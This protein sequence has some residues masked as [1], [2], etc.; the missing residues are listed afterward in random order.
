VAAF[1]PISNLVRIQLS[2]LA[3]EAG[4]AALSRRVNVALLA[5]HGL[6]LLGVARLAHWPAWAAAAL[7]AGAFLAGAGRRMGA[8]ALAPL[9][10]L[11]GLALVRLGWV[12]G[13]RLE[14]PESLSYAW[15]LAFCAAWVGLIHLR[16]AGRLHWACALA[17]AGAALLLGAQLWRL[18]PA[19]VTGSDPYAYVQMGV[20]LAERGTARHAFPLAVLAERLDLPT[21]PTTH[22][23]Y[24]LPNAE[25][26]AP[27]VWPPG[28]SVMLAGVYQL[29]GDRAMLTFNA[30][31]AVAGAAVAAALGGLLAG[32][33][34]RRWAVAAGGAAAF[35]LATA[36]EQF[37]RQVVPLADGAAQVLTGLAVLPAVWLVQTRHQEGMKAERDTKKIIW[38]GLL[39][40]LALAAAYS[41]RYTQ[42]LAAGGIAAGAWLGLKGWKARGAFVGAAGAAA[43]AGALPDVLYR[44]GLYGSPWRFGTG[45]LDLFSLSAL[46]EA[47]GRLGAEALAGSEF[48]WLWPLMLVGGLVA[49]QRARGPLLVMLAAYGPVL[50]FHV[51]YPFVRL[52]D[53]LSLYPL[54]AALAAVGAVVVAR[55]A[56]SVMASRQSPSPPPPP[57]PLR[58]GGHGLPPGEGSRR[59]PGWQMTARAAIVAGV[60]AAVFARIGPLVAHGPLVFT[61]GYLLP[62][63][64]ADLEALA[65]ITEPNAVIAC[66]LNSGAVELYGKRLAVRPGRELQ[67]GAA[68]TEAEWLRFAEG[69]RAEGRPLYV[70]MDSPEMAAPLRAV[71]ERYGVE[72]VAE[73]DV[74]VFAVGG[75]STNMTVPLYR[76]AWP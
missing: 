19:G 73:V 50:L 51:W 11:Y 30:W 3:L 6:G 27:T 58:S 39:A 13:L 18:A 69:L 45:E 59:P 64:R 33:G 20:D 57:T 72:R 9:G 12:Y 56:W 14:A 35:A 7:V 38:V 74:P 32:S 62:H 15:M 67:P 43:L 60:L 44:V 26:L 34:N 17:G 65:A 31:L 8:S 46:P 49:W 22:V 16:A 48:G 37:T 25:G 36:P 29:G 52:R 47:L 5:L 40:G 2:A 71:A 68:W 66:S 4:G 75:G 24:V 28:Y 41:V 1:S 42:V 21:L 54:A 55:G 76:V 23:G 61:F 70:L 10:G 63:Q 53:L